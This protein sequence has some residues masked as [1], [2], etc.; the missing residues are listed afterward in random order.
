MFVYLRRMRKTLA[1]FFSNL[2]KIYPNCNLRSRSIATSCSAC[3]WMYLTMTS[4]HHQP[5]KIWIISQY[6][7]QLFLNS[8]I[9]P[10]DK[11]A[12]CIAPSAIIWRQISP[13]S[14]GSHYPKYSVNK[15]AIA[16]CYP[17]QPPFRPGKCGAGFVQAS[18][19]RSC[20]LCAHM[21]ASNAM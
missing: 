7:Q 2:P 3:L 12:M 13:W 14:P 21:N 11:T 20:L 8:T 16:H 4:I 18:S 5:L 1:R 17:P 6:F 10:T 15:L 19:D 9:P